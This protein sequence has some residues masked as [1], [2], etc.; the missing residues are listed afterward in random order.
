MS[1]EHIVKSYDE[2]LNRL[3]ETILKMGGL[4]ESQL[5]DAIKSIAMRDPDLAAETVREDVKID[6]LEAE[7]DHMAVRLLALRQPM[8]KDLRNIV[9]ALKVSSDIERIG[10]YSANVAKRAI[11]IA[12]SR[13]VRPVG[14]IPRMGRLVQRLI[15][16]VLDA[17]T[18]GNAEKAKDVWM[19]DAE[20]DEL[21]NSLFR[22]VLTYMMEDP[23]N[24]TPCTHLLFIAKNIE[25]IGDHATNI[26][27]IIY[28]MVTGKALTEARPKG[29]DV[30]LTK[31]MPPKA[32]GKKD[33]A[34]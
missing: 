31:V 32:E 24:I 12:E 5:A 29:E 21:Y 28:F 13:H 20:V 16:E 15:K 6:E 14:G 19:R 33:D 9:A 8:A 25:R 1:S 18:E 26:A 2:E 34:V 30:S 3:N 22:E 11:V 10:D 4:A 17:Y 27:E 23:R 7:V